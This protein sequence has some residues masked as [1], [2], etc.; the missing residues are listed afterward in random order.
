[1]S[2]LP[3]TIRLDGELIRTE[4]AFHQAIKEQSG[5]EWYG[6]NLDALDETGAPRHVR[7]LS[8]THPG[9]GYLGLEFQRSYSSN[10]RRG[11]HRD[12]AYVIDAL[13][14]RA[15]RVRVRG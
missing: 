14:S 3:F 8:S 11:V 13:A 1:M 10:T 7:G 4:A 2:D 5:I 6:C 9:L 12:A 15:G